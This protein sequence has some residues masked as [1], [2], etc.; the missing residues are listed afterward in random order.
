MLKYS[1]KNNNQ[2]GNI[3]KNAVEYVFFFSDNVPIK[4]MTFAKIVSFI[5]EI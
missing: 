3:I 2:T 4:K 5:K 1:E